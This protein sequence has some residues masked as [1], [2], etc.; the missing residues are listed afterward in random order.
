MHRLLLVMVLV[1]CARPHQVRPAAL[2]TLEYRDVVAWLQSG[3]LALRRIAGELAIPGDDVEVLQN[4]MMQHCRKRLLARV[5]LCIDEL[6]ALADVAVSL[7]SGSS[8]MD[9]AAVELVRTWRYEPVVIDERP[10]LVCTTVTFVV[11]ANTHTIGRHCTGIH[12]D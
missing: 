12:P 6:G 11:R 5:D 3:D 4:Q 7:P 2:S 10:A 8:R 1:A 9:R